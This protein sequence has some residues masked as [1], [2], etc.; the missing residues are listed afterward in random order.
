MI[1]NQDT[2]RKSATPESQ[3]ASN[4]SVAP[5]K[6]S[7]CSAFVPTNSPTTPPAVLGNAVPSQCR[8]ASPQLVS[9]VSAKPAD[10][11]RVLI[12]DRASG[13]DCSLCTSQPAC[14]SIMGNRYAGRPNSEK[15]KPASQAPTGPIQLCSSADSPVFQKLGSSL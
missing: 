6:L 10:R 2:P 11:S 15:K 14:A 8:V 7:A 12:R 9:K 4:K 13:K 3:S 1:S 5:R